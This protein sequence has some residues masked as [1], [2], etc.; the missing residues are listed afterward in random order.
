M[1]GLYGEPLGVDFSHSLAA[2]LRARLRDH[3]PEAMARVTLLVNTTRLARRVEAALMAG[4]PTLLPRI[5]LVSD[6]ASLLPPGAAPGATVGPLALR[7]RLTRLVATLLR[8]APDL[9]PVAAAFD[10]AG[11]LA[12]LLAEMEEE[13]LSSDGLDCIDVGD[14][15][16]HWEQSRQFLRIATDWLDGAG[17]LTPAG[18]NALALQ[19]LLTH[20]GQTPPADPVIVAGST[21][22]RAPTRRLIEAVLDLPQGAVVLPGLDTDMPEPAW[23]DLVAGDGPGR[24]DHPQ[25]RLAALL[26]TRGVTRAEV[27]RWEDTPPVAPDR[28]RL[29]SLALRPAPATDAW[30]EEGPALDGLEEACASITLLEAPSPGAE[31]AAIACGL[32]DALHRGVRSALITPDRTLARQVGAQLGRW[33]IVPDDSA[34]RPLNQSAPGRLMLHV[35]QMRGRRPEAEALSILL[36]HP[37]THSGGDRADHLAHARALEVGLLR[38]E[39]LPFPTAEAV[40]A[41]VD[42]PSTALTPD[43]WSE[44]LCGLL[45][46]LAAD[47]PTATLAEHATR[48]LNLVE[49]LAGGRTAVPGPLWD[50]DAGRAVH[51]IVR[52]LI[53]NAPERGDAALD[54]REFARILQGLL[55]S[56]EVRDTHASNPDVMIWGAIEARARHADLVI[57]GGLNDDVWPGQPAPDPWLNRAMRAACGLRLPE[58]RVGLSA[59]DFQQAVSAPEIWLSRSLRGT[60]AETVPSRWLNRIE[61]LLGGI[62][63][64]G[65]AALRDMRDRGR[66]WLATAARLD[67]PDDRHPTRAAV[68]PGPVPP[69]GVALDRISV[70]GVETLIRDPYAI[71]ARD[72]LGLR[73][74]PP[75]RQGPDGRVRG[76]AVHDAMER[77]TRA[78]PGPLPNDAAE[79]LRA[80]FERALEDGAPWPGARRLWLGRFGRVIPDFLVAEAARRARGTPLLIEGTGRLAFARPPFTLTARADRMDLRDDGVAIYDYKSGP[81][82]SEA[83]QKHYAK[84]LLLE[85][86]MVV[87]G[88]FPD[89][90]FREVREVAYLQVGN[91]YAEMAPKDFGPD[92]INA[93]RTG[94]IE[95]M[96]HYADGAP[97]VARL[98][99]DLLAYA[100][101]YDQLSR[102]GEWDDT[103]PAIR[104]PLAR[105]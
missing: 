46:R 30:R 89:L 65:Q 61:G 93:T 57:L 18:E 47:P 72:I 41:W 64:R 91:R 71:Y 104:I 44:W 38:R 12:D 45:D 21:A 3:P 78:T 11:S 87:E 74:M 5:R 23:Q 62:G 9:S 70:T 27:P 31:A 53:A 97:F 86:M 54:A 22:S 68:R 79:R 48:H 10:L 28:N 94:L 96:A 14:L 102:F 8:A 95:L 7:L 105:S 15:S 32:R 39:P 99:P 49:Y 84:Q 83:Q 56:E 20:W 17:D 98:A 75:L 103:I 60:E 73:A 58:R 33:G 51:R 92:L 13:G 25:F 76:S 85:A 4:G 82:P 77:F 29:V 67:M 55:S 63:P 40:M 42:D 81:P 24:Q 59:H 66:A 100:S 43:D 34:G 2:G 19:T 26:A 37:L 1:R 80:A 36:E 101:D 35:A 69:A 50:G 88:A 6:L 52:D 16:R 90:P